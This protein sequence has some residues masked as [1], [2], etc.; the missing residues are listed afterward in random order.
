[1]YFDAI[2]DSYQQ[3][4]RKIKRLIPF[5]ELFLYEKITS[6]GLLICALSIFICFVMNVE[7]GILISFVLGI[8][9]TIIRI[10]KARKNTELVIKTRRIPY[11]RERMEALTK[12]L[13][14]HQINI[15]DTKAIDQ[16]IE[17]FTDEQKA[18]APFS[19]LKKTAKT[20]LPLFTAIISYIAA[21]IANGVDIKNI[22]D[23]SFIAIVLF[24]ILISVFT[25]IY[26]SIRASGLIMYDK[27]DAFIRDIKQLKFLI[28]NHISWVD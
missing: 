20:L 22:I 12:V 8:I 18:F 15:S 25:I 1:M 7:I 11:M 14:T 13:I 19:Y 4:I 27:Y 9:L 28:V 3:A 2:F 16:I 21:R 23:L 5:K 26:S 10:C 24:V 6:I 17:F